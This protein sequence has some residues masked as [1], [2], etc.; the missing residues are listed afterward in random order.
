MQE[1]GKGNVDA[2]D[3]SDK[4]RGQTAPFFYIR[5][6]MRTL[7]V[8]FLLTLS[9]HIL[10]QRSLAPEPSWVT[11]VTD[12]TLDPQ[13]LNEAEDGFIN[14][15][16]E[17]E[18][19]LA[20]QTIY[21]RISLQ[22]LTEA[23]VQASSTIDVDYDPTYERLVW[24]K[25]RIIRDGKIINKLDLSKIKTERQEEDLDRNV[26]NG[27]M[28]AILFLEDVRKGD[29]ID[30]SYSLQGFNPLFR[31]RY[32]ASYPLQYQRPLGH[33]LYK[34]ICPPGR[35]L[36]IRTHLTQVKPEIKV[37][38]GGKVYEWQLH[39]VHSMDPEHDLPGWYDPY[40]GVE[41]SEYAS[42]RDISQWAMALFPASPALSPGLSKK[43]AEIEKR[44]GTDEEKKVLGALRFVQDEVRYMGIEM[45]ENS[46]KPH[47]PAGIFN[48]RFGDCKDKSFLLCTMLRVMHIDAAPV[49]IS[50][51]DKQELHQL[52][53]SPLVFDHC[54][55][56]VRLGDKTYWF[57]PTISYQRGGIRDISFPN[58]KCGLVLTDTTTTLTDIPLQDVGEVVSKEKFNLPDTYGAGKL[59]VI[60]IYTGSYADDIRSDFNST[61]RSALQKNYLS[62]YKGFYE[63]IKVADTLKVEDDEVTG[64]FVTREYYTIEK[65]WD[66]TKG[67]QRANF[68]AVLINSVMHKPKDEERTAPAQ[69]A[70]PIRYTEEI[71]IR[72]PE[73]WR[74]DSGGKTIETSSFKY[75]CSTS[76][77]ERGVNLTYKYETLSDHI[78]AGEMPEYVKNYDR[79]SND[80]D[81]VLTN[82]VNGRSSSDSGSSSRRK[83]IL[84]SLSDQM[85]LTIVLITIGILATV[86]VKRRR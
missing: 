64:K 60:S 41:I 20:T 29:V 18:V 68:E 36:T 33:M 67:V 16:L 34:V 24:H 4:K 1:D 47:D 3:R 8:V 57:D 44:A 48:Q 69:L 58:Y 39:N 76:A 52:L 53:P 62:F 77:T 83:G 85:K 55:V 43:I 12:N 9:N 80:L 40:P 56:R 35:E 21:R 61:S 27:T 32:S 6:I 54:T 49:L 73:D 23:G 46:H 30:Y 75:S 22:M 13:L 5:G 17:R 66:Q 78:A 11:H 74:F 70:Y 10:G 25:I 51:T 72:V 15:T 79:V 38:G 7:T 37:Q 31:D 50:T 63:G 45:G 19:N 2:N 42:W 81:Y 26:Y 82:D 28:K 71:E 84:D 14:H 86:Y 59:E 65:L